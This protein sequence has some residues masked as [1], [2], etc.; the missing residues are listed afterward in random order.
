[1]STTLKFEVGQ[2]Q[3]KAL[4][5]IARTYPSL[6]KVLLEVI[7]NSIDA[8][9][10]RVDA[11]INQQKRNFAV[12]D[13]GK[14]CGPEE[15]RERLLDFENSVVD[16]KKY[17]QFRRGVV[18]P[19]AVA[20]EGFIFTSCAHPHRDAYHAYVFD[21]KK[22]EPAPKVIIEGRPVIGLEFSPNG[23]T[24]W[25]TAV[26]ARKIIKDRRQSELKLDDLLSDIA[27]RYGEAIRSRNIL[28]SVTLT[29][30]DGNTDS[31][32]VVAAE[33]SGEAIGKVEMESKEAGR[34]ILDLYVARLGKQGRKG[35]ITV[36]M[37]NS[38]SRITMGDFL[39]NIRGTKLLSGQVMSSLGSGLLEGKILCEKLTLDPDRTKFDDN[40]ALA[41]MCLQIEDW[42][43]KTGKDIV[44]K[45]REQDSANRFQEFGEQ[46]MPFLKL[47]L[48]QDRFKA[49]LELIRVGTIGKE[50]SKVADA[51]ILGPED[52]TSVAEAGTKG[53]KTKKRGSGGSG[54]GDKPSKERPDHHPITS[55]GSRGGRRV[56]VL[57]S[58]T[59]IRFHYEE[60]VD[61]TL[62][63]V[64]EP[65]T[66]ILTFNLDHPDWGNCEVSNKIPEYEMA[67]VM[68]ALRMEQSCSNVSL[69]REEL[70]EFT[71]AMLHDQVFIILH[72]EGTLPTK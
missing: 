12:F 31:R 28:V 14:G 44:E 66:G 25:R 65:A 3:G 35:V 38:L 39:T 64:F 55:R 61:I 54:G 6:P 32:N 49:V 8:G 43:E 19:L 68:A 15:L 10:K 69:H 1:M 40:D 42:W 26:E 36:G 5:R 70:A 59:G 23:K 53:T 63:F 67:V 7:Q 24:W 51:Q 50:H 58:S 13:N 33:Y 60:M 72:G 18:A 29:D 71:Y 56:E 62:P 34:T 30:A 52:G 48:K 57:D 17:G 27:L 22:I 20:E 11:I 21:P 9:A 47:I 4:M 45:L 2:H 41:Y 37:T 46:V 16:P